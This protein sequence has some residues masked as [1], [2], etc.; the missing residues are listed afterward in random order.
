MMPG[1]VASLLLVAGIILMVTG[2]KPYV[3]PGTR[4]VSLIVLFISVIA[5]IPLPIW[6]SPQES[7]FVIHVSAL[8]ILA[9]GFVS[10]I[11]GKSEA[12]G[13]G[14]LFAVFVLL[15]ILWGCLRSLYVH[16]PFFHW[17]EPGWDAALLCGLLTSLFLTKTSGQVGLLVWCSAFGELFA[18][19]LDQGAYVARLGSPQWLDILMLSIAVALCGN[20]IQRIAKSTG[21]RL[22]SFVAGA[23]GGR[24]PS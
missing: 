1:Y 14:L 18:A 2:W 16:E 6:I 5:L 8:P 17:L 19:W 22:A 15:S 13:H 24:N 11:R 23:K 20:G 7:F 3:A 4:N 9:A 21:L 12:G 10:F